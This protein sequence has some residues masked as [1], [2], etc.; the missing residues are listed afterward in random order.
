[1]Q[2][3]KT[4]SGIEY[5]GF[6]PHFYYI[7]WHL[8]YVYMKNCV[9]PKQYSCSQANVMKCP[10]ERKSHRQ[11]LN[12]KHI[13]VTEICKSKGDF[14]WSLTKIQPH[15][16]PNF[17][18]S[19]G[20]PLLFLPLHTFSNRLSPFFIILPRAASVFFGV[21]WEWRSRVPLCDQILAGVTT[22]Q[23]IEPLWVVWGCPHRPGWMG[24][25]ATWFSGRRPWSR[26]TG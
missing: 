23:Q 6:S 1:M 24:P 11:I 10:R 13:V 8:W 15:I 5:L 2:F 9:T 7:N 14:S 4:T 12:M 22:L 25:W 19:R 3:H 20:G 16:F 17:F 21:C 26:Q 18:C